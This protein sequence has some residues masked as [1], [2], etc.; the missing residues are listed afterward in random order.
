MTHPCGQHAARQ[1][2]LR[3]S[4]HLQ[5]THRDGL[6]TRSIYC[7]RQIPPAP[8]GLVASGYI[9]TPDAVTF[10]VGPTGLVYDAQHDILYVAS[11]GDTEVFAIPNSGDRSTPL[12]NGH[13]T[14]TVVNGAK[15]RQLCDD[16][17]VG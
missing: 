6:S 14:G 2:T 7:R 10:E 1:R 15:I 16:C 4:L 17:G 8:K 12:P 13:S 5:C 9:H 3:E 11:T